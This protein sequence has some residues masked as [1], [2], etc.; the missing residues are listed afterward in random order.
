MRLLESEDGEAKE[1][2]M[3]WETIKGTEARTSAGIS[4]RKKRNREIQ[5]IKVLRDSE[6]A[7][8]NLYLCIYFHLDS[9]TRKELTSP[10][11]LS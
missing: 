4:S 6:F 1:M 3:G 11:P 5:L 8:L 9:R 10:L 2:M 7:Q